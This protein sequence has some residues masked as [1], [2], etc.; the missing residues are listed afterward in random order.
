MSE[1]E[2]AAL[3]ALQ[4]RLQGLGASPA[5]LEGWKAL[6]HG[7][8]PVFSRGGRWYREASLIKK[9]VPGHPPQP[10]AEPGNDLA[11]QLR[12]RESELAES[13]E[14]VRSLRS[15]LQTVSQQCNQLRQSEQA[16][17]DE[18]MDMDMTRWAPACLHLTCR[19]P[20]GPP[21]GSLHR[22]YQ[23]DV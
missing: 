16:L 13:R 23:A 19:L 9:L 3:Q 17:R 15:L 22:L 7:R 10:Q 11:S 8:Q 12:Q 1:A 2:Q 6:M 18:L 21:R 5:A 4:S 20:A 14:K